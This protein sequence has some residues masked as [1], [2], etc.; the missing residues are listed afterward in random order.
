MTPFLP[1]RLE[2]F[3]FGY[4]VSGV[5]SFQVSGMATASSLGVTP[6]FARDWMTVWLPAWGIAFPSAVFFAPVLRRAL[7]AV[8]KP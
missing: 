6:N 2:P 5:M 7:E 3:V 8:V 1:R 4:L